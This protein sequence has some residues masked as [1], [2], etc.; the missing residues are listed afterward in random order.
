MFMSTHIA[1]HTHT[2]TH[3]HTQPNTHTTTPHSAG[4]LSHSMEQ[5]SPLPSDEK[6]GIK[7]FTT[8]VGTPQISHSTSKSKLKRRN[9]EPDMEGAC[10]CVDRPA[11]VLGILCM[12]LIVYRYTNSEVVLV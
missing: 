5:L 12:C 7:G 6:E 3:T 2:H 10:E 8:P 1:T 4:H 9:S 11:T